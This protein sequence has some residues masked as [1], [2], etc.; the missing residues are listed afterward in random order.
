MQ[1]KNINIANDDAQLTN[2]TKIVIGDPEYGFVSAI[3]H[4]AHVTSWLTTDGKEM[5][6]MSGDAIYR[7]GFPI[8]GGVP[9]VFPQFGSRGSL[10]KH[11]FARTEAWN[12]ARQGVNSIE[13]KLTEIRDT[14]VLWPHK[15]LAEYSVVL[16]KEELELSFS[17]RNTDEHNLEFTA[18]LHTYF[19]VNDIHTAEI[20]GLQGTDYMDETAS[21][22]RRLTQV[23]LVSF[24]GEVD[25][26]FINSPNRVILLSAGCPQVNIL[27]AGF[28]DTVV[29]NPGPEK[30]KTIPDLAPDDYLN[31]VCVES[32]IVTHPVK[33]N[34]GEFWQG[35]Q[36]LIKKIS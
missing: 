22:S 25:R 10:P 20:D 31:F 21:D 4:G 9:I 7:K 19:W 35:T 6:F 16:K 29:W 24:E 33:L 3:P 18:A 34:P 32:A 12:L 13:F 1:H 2:F 23:G 5:L 30:A 14:S 8:R 11:G 26:V 17:I 28:N 15:F 27:S 36:R